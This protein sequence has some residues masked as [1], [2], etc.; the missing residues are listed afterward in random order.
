MSGQPS[1]RLTIAISDI[2]LYKKQVVISHLTAYKTTK[3]TLLM[4]TLEKLC[5]F[6]LKLEKK[7][8]SAKDL[9]PEAMLINDLNLDSLDM[10]ELLVMAEDTFSIK[11]PLDDAVK[12]MSIGA[13]A[14]YFDER[15]AEKG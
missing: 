8:L 6:I 14:Q 7:N 15:I 12:L 2:F 13:A 3:E 4:T 10:A 11:I 5:E 9:K 1:A